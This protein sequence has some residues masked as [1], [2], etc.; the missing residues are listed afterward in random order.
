MTIMMRGQGR[1]VGAAQRGAG[2]REVTI[3][4]LLEWA[5]RKEK[6]RID[7][8]Q[9]AGERPQGAL[10]GYGMEYLLV[11]QAELGCRVQGGGTSE[12][13]PDADLVAD[14]LA[15]LPEGV[16][17]RRMALVLAELARTGETMGW[18]SDLA[19]QV[20]PVEWKQTKHGLFAATEAC[21]K[22]RYESRGKVREVELRCCPVT[23]EN[24]PRDQARARRDYL[25]YWSA[26]KELRDSFQICRQLTAHQVTEG[27]PPMKPWEGR[28]DRARAA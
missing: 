21:G 7:F 4:Q 25:L 16:G 8:E 15:V 10:K 24:H 6:V 12:Q 5:F 2:K 27:L 26:L 19:P 17:G 9:G 22:A 1:R 18:G 13:H 28:K 14:A 23:I 20:Q 3:L 11:K